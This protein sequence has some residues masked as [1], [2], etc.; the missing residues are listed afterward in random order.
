M[1]KVK[2]VRS[3]SFPDPYFPVFR[4]N[5]ESYYSVGMRENTDQNNSKY[6]YF[7]RSV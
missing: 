7:L 3:Q 5:T 6:G 4:L 1:W 2:S